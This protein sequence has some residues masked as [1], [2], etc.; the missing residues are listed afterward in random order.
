M[1]KIQAKKMTPWSVAVAL[2]LTFVLVKFIVSAAVTEGFRHLGV[3]AVLFLVPLIHAGRTSFFYPDLFRRAQSLWAAIICLGYVLL[4]LLIVLIAFPDEWLRIRLDLQ[5]WVFSVSGLAAVILAPL[6]EEFYFR[7]WL[8]KWQCES[9]C[10]TA[11]QST[12]TRSWAM[13]LKICYVN[14]LLFWVLHIPVTENFFEVWGEALKKGL[15]PVSPGP[16]L[17]GLTTSL[18]VMISGTP[19]SA[20]VFHALANALGPLWWPLLREHHIRSIFYF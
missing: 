14:A 11:Q 15:I 16:F 12:D 8:L 5:S 17:L 10:T 20:L 9:A 2:M 13:N 1:T 19:R 4:P 3:A 6:A 18:L 7:G